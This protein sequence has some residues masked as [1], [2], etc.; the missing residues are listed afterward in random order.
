MVPKEGDRRI[1]KQ[2]LSE[3]GYKKGWKSGRKTLNN[4]GEGA[5]KVK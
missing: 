3:A 5:Q 4:K 2:Q 1:W